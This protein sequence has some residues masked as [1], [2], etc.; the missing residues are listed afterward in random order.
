M[1][2]VLLLV[3]VI[4]LAA[5]PEFRVERVPVAGGAELLTVFASTPD[6]TE[7]E[8]PLLSL[9]RDTLGDN[10]PS[11]DRL[12]SL[13]ILTSANPSPLQRAAGAI[14]FFYWRPNLGKSA[15]KTPGPVL[16][17]ANTSSVVWSSL[18]QSLTQVMAVDSMGAMIR[19]STRRY[20]TNLSDRR[21]VHLI[22][23]LT[24][25]SSVEELPEVHAILS[26]PE[27][28]EVQAR[29]M[30]AGQTLGGLVT[31]EKLPD[32]YFKRRGQTQETLGHNWELLRQSAEANGL[33][34]DP[35]GV[36]DTSTH[37]L[38]WIA[39]DD[40]VSGRPFNGRFLDIQN[41]YGDQRVQ[42]WS[43]VSVTRFYDPSGREVAPG[44]TGAT[45]RELIPLALYGLDYPKVPLLLV[46]FRNTQS[47][48]R[49]EMLGRAASDV[50][51]GVLGVSRWGNWPYMAGSMSWNFLRARRGVPT[52]GTQR[53]EA[54]A[55]VRRWLAL[56]HALDPALRTELQQRL[57]MMGVNPLEESIFDENKFAH[58]RY[59]ALLAY[60]ADPKGLPAQLEKD[61]AAEL[62]AYDHGALAR[63][64][65]KLAHFATFGIYA[66][67]EPEQ[68]E[69]LVAVLDKQRRATSEIRFLET[70][71]KSSPNP[72]LVWDM[73][74]V[75]RS[76]DSLSAEG[77]PPRSAN[78]V[79]K[80]L[81]Q[82]T[83]E[84]T[85]AL[86]ER[87]LHNLH[88]ATD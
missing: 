62:T 33:Y 65:L 27:L 67:H 42:Q 21:R 28:Q 39:R 38:L 6:N 20:R 61:R 14:P 25:L 23:G 3:P 87:A 84:G 81:A 64:G 30:L 11:N 24:V 52:N 35:L 71:L 31:A 37:V 48:K 66:H 82:T 69:A 1:R 51:T 22:E 54:Y 41:P 2:W 19:A 43:G 13:W 55:G 53:L 46:D 8:V 56:D 80:I 88:A 86:F 7:P 78:A 18:A 44:T 85:R 79:E 17:L 26:D 75:L 76:L 15:S 58:K 73:E 72:E 77:F 60:A 63:T 12:R 5:E 32:A 47:P 40:A 45:E 57:E 49:R 70:V 83:D 34:F 74:E 9:L 50:I 59:E 68:H 4:A 29:L 36:S 16:D 10:D